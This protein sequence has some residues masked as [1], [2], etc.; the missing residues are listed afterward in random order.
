MENRL[1]PGIAFVGIRITS[2]VSSSFF[3]VLLHSIVFVHLLG[4]GLGVKRVLF[5][6]KLPAEAVVRR[7]WRCKMIAYPPAFS[8]MVLTIMTAVFG[9]YLEREGAGSLHFILAVVL[10]LAN[11]A[12]IWVEIRMIDENT[13]IIRDV[14]SS[15]AAL[16]S[17]AGS[18]QRS[19]A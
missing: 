6:H 3:F 1:L 19:E 16:Q 11:I 13:G 5:E 15:L 7:L 12:T 8:C 2:V 9:G 14:E 18:V 10:L 17:T 4:T